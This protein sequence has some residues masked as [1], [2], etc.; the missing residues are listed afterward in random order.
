MQG[1]F[2]DRV[3]RLDIWKEDALIYANLQKQNELPNFINVSRGVDIFK[4]SI[5]STI[6]IHVSFLHLQL[7]NVQEI[8]SSQYI[9]LFF[10]ILE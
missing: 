2:K 8:R 3:D 6:F 10:E 9:S 5:K 4:V 1:P 7:T